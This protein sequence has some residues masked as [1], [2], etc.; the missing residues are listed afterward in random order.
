MVLSKASNIYCIC[1]D[2]LRNI[3]SMVRNLGWANRAS[4]RQY[5]AMVIWQIP[6]LLFENANQKKVRKWE[7]DIPLLSGQS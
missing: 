3:F 7:S 6:F 5:Q 4:L 2:D 1:D